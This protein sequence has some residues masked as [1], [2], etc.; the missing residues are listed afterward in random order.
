MFSSESPTV[1]SELKS[2]GRPPQRSSISP[3]NDI[4]ARADPPPDFPS[5]PISVMLVDDHP[6]FR[7][8]V[9]RVLDKH[10][11][12]HVVAETDDGLDAV[13]LAAT[14]KPDVAVLDIGLRGTSGLVAV[15]KIKAESPST[16]ILVLTVHDDAEHVRSMLQG[17]ASGFLTK[18]VLGGEVVEAIRRVAAGDIYLCPVALRHVVATAVSDSA[19]TSGCGS[20]RLTPRE[21]EVLALLSQGLSNREIAERLS[22]STRTVKGHLEEIFAKLEVDSRTAAVTAALRLKILEV[23]DL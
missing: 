12:F 10:P 20:P 16:A 14:L 22:L 8:A 3:T 21:T 6:L 19:T 2:D 17:G 7:D 4:A 15:H 23:Q 13:R 9:K 1:M 11:E 18:D 5:R